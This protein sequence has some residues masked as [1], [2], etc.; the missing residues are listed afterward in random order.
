MRGQ[1]PRMKRKE[2]TPG[3]S[4]EEGIVPE[5]STAH[6]GPTKRHGVESRVSSGDTSSSS[7]S[8]GPGAQV[9]NS[10]P[11]GCCGVPQPQ[12]KMRHRVEACAGEEEEDGGSPSG[13][14]E[15]LE[16]VDGLA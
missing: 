15:E 10:K 5:W 8:S 13:G 14:G 12:K 9:M 2:I 7:S 16:I 6:I 1:A 4:A 11:L 3:G